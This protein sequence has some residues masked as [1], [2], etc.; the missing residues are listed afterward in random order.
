MFREGRT[1]QEKWPVASITGNR[2]NGGGYVA[3]GMEGQPIPNSEHEIDEYLPYPLMQPLTDLLD[4]WPP[5]VPDIPT[6]VPNVH[7]GSLARFDYRD[8]TQRNEA[9]RLQMH[10]IP[11][12]LTNVDDVDRVTKLWSDDYLIREFGNR[13]QHVLKSN[14]NHFMY[15]SKQSARNQRESYTPPTKPETMSFK[16][17]LHNRDLAENQPVESDHIYLQI[18]S[19]AEHRFI[20]R[21]LKIFEAKKSFWIVDPK[22]NRGINCRWGAKGIIAETHY[23]GGRNFVAM[24]RGSKRYLLSP[25][26]DCP[27]LYLWPRGHPEGRHSK[28]DWSQ[29]DLE[30]YPLMKRATGTQVVVR[31]GEVLYIPSYWFHYIVSQDGS[32]QCNTRSGSSIRGRDHIKSCGFY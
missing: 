16:E 4:V 5:D 29:L 10:E 14:T 28:A 21:D 32:V 20:P 15:W 12:M 6:N 19:D 11:F 2:P 17:F 13:P 22:K 30:K 25:P 26:V 27:N 18:N 3:T 8:L 24:L 31:A 23:D 1:L 7:A 9:K